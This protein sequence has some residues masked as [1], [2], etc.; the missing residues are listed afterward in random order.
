MRFVD[1]SHVI[2]D[3]LETYPGLPAPRIMDHL[4]REA[5]RSVY[6][7]GTEFQI[8]RIEMVANT[9]TYLDAPAHRWA[10]GADLSGL[11]LERLADLPGVVLDLAPGERAFRALDLPRDDLAGCAL[12]LRTG[13]SAHFGTPRYR[14][15][16]PYLAADAA[17]ELVK[18]GVALVGIDSLNID[19]TATGE[20]PAHSLLLRAGIP[21]V[22]H[23]TN[24]AALP[25]R[26]FRFSAVP[27]KVSGMGTFPVRAFARLGE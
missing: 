20:R 17:A 24:L 11:A 9:G 8:G 4:S 7:P 1:L 5:S 15:G 22:E 23:L 13:W 26:G 18:R 14:E 19:D 12:L 25:S 16:H 21:I 2:R 6:A 27:P 3:G 10:D